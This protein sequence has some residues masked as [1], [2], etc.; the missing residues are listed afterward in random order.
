MTGTTLP[1]AAAPSQSALPVAPPV[2]IAAED[3]AVGAAC[4]PTGTGRTRLR[5]DPRLPAFL[6]STIVHTL[7]LV[8][9]ALWTY[10]QRETGNGALTARLGDPAPV[11]ELRAIDSNDR[12]TLADEALADQPIS[13]VIAPAE[14]QAI[15]SPFSLSLNSQSQ[16]PSVVELSALGGVSAKSAPLIRLP[17]GGLEGRTPEGRIKYGRKYGATPQSEAAVD[18]A[19]A[20][21]AE[22]QRPNGSWSFDLELDPCNGRCRHSKKTGIETPTPSTGATGLALLAFLGAGHTHH[23]EGQYRETVRRGLYYLRAVAAETETG[24]HWQQGSMYGHGIALMALGEALSMSTEGEKY[25]ADLY[26]LVAQGTW[27]TCIAQHRNGSWGYVPGSPGDT[28]VTGWQVLSLI[29]AKRSRVPMK[30][31]V[32]HDAKDFVLS[33]CRDRDYWF[34]YKEPPGEPT[35]TAIGLTLMLYLG[36]S[37]N[38]TPFHY[39]LSD[40]AERGPTLT[41]IYHDYYGTLALHHSRHRD[42]DEWNRKLRDHL[43]STQ[44]T[45]GH[46]KGSWHFPDRWG[47]VGGRLYTTAMCAMTLEV[48][49]RYLPLYEKLDEFPL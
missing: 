39:A 38:F 11:L 7:L 49:Y 33:T 37:L 34:G 27:F 24:Y 28:T 29:A 46:E 18:A 26:D 44:A 10:R 47:D 45:T 40:L 8:I 35:T 14:P 12:Q 20:W 42:W 30:T 25:D 23:R 32:L 6:I 4:E 17:G 43:V 21:L 1:S 19:L 36:E 16:E 13:V 2:A 5:D 22:H 9:L 15:A 3:P 31:Y 41:N 48:Y